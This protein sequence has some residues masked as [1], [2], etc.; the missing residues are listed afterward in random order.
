M[1]ARLL[2]ADAQAIVRHGLRRILSLTGHIRV[3]GEAADGKQ[4]MDLLC[5][6][7]FDLALLDMNMPDINGMELIMRI[8]A[9]GIGIPL[10][11][12]SLMDDPRIARLA[13]KAGASGYLSKDSSPERLIAAVDGLAAGGN[14][15]LPAR[16]QS[17]STRELQV[18]RMLAAGKRVNDIADELSLSNKAVSTYKTRLMKKM[19][20]R[21]DAELMCYGLARM[22]SHASSP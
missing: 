1:T 12:F 9:A 16:E 18:L 4:T 2:I 17:L 20:F 15:A 7:S 19:D 21:N 6:E 13:L 11:A 3:A 22:R 14:P 10:L 8:R 5:K